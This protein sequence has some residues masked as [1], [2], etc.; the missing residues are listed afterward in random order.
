MFLISPARSVTRKPVKSDFF[1]AIA[2]DNNVLPEKDCNNAPI[3]QFE[4]MKFRPVVSDTG[5]R[6]LVCRVVFQFLDI[7]HKNMVF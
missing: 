1:S 5:S 3:N 6:V 7:F 4:I 2:K